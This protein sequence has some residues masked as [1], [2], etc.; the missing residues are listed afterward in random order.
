M[1]CAKNRWTDVNDRSMRDVTSFSQKAVPF[2]TV[3]DNAAHIDSQ[4]PPKNF[5]GVNRLLKSNA[6]Y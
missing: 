6:K 1:S 2:G 5:R 3:V 4:I